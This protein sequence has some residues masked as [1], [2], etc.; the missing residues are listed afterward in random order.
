MKIQFD[1]VVGGVLLYL[2]LVAAA[3]L[4]RITILVWTARLQ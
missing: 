1:D 2:L 4:T 3:L